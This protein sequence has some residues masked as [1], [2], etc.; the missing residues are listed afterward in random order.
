MR[1]LAQLTKLKPLKQ[2]KLSIISVRD[3]LGV[4]LPV[5]ALI[6]VAFWVAYLFVQPAPPRDI[7]ISTGSELGAYHSFGQRY[8]EALARHGIDATLKPSAGSLDN[9]SRLRDPES[10][11]DVAFIQSG[12]LRADE[13]EG[14]VSLGAIYYE[15]VWV[16]YRSKKPLDRVRELSGMRVSIGPEG[17]G[18]RQLALGILRANEADGPPTRLHDLPS[19]AGAEALL[20]G[21]ID[22]LFIV[23]APETG[24][25]RAL[26]YAPELRLMSFSRA[27]AYTRLFPFMSSVTL[28][29]GSIDLV[30][31]IPSQDTKLIA[32]TAQ[33]MVRDD[34]HPAL[35]NLLMQTFQ[36]V[37]GGVGALHRAGD[38]PNARMTDLPLAKES[39]RFLKSGPPLLQRYLPF[40]AA[41]L[42]DRLLVLIVPLVAVMVPAIRIAPTLYAWRV[43][44]KIA[45]QYGELKLL[46]YEIRNRY[47]PARRT[48]YDNQLEAL[49]DQAFS[50]SIPLGF[51][52]QV[53]ILREHIDL[54]RHILER[55]TAGEQVEP[56]RGAAPPPANA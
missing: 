46:E 8:R 42:V 32:T 6:A 5:L 53:Y 23:A 34:F 54:V 22:A 40:W 27:H 15:P 36:D 33:I 38:F 51:T 7:V 3:A 28:P 49:E 30:R 56:L 25:V 11:V 24:I 26:L 16:F 31:D 19:E 41:T 50:G 55:R 9:L 14:L 47:D 44:S 29:Q 48:E 45:R 18:M 43:R 17:S 37:H 10:G 1:H 13:S 2:I 39:Q 21:E 12:I 20:R 35:T 52:D 4:G